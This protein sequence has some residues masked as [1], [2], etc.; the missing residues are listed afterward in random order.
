MKITAADRQSLFDLSLQVC[1]S[2]EAVFE[3]A[4]VNGMSITDALAPGQGLEYNAN[5]IRD[6]QVVQHY[7]NN[8]V[9]PS[10]AIT[11]ESKIM[12][13]GVEYWSIE[14]DFKIS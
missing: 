5:S 6:K 1:G 2:I 9:I 11:E 8:R 12:P 14:L 7:T 13:E 10:T 4:K 3:L